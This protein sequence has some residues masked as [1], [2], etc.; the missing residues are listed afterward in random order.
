VSLKCSV[1]AYQLRECQQSDTELIPLLE[2][3]LC[4]SE[5]AKVPSCFYMKSG[6]L[7]RKW[8]PPT[9]AADEEWRVGHQT[10]VPNCYCDD[11][12]SLEHELPL[13]G[14]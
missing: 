4:E 11:I 2:D 12:L 3:V 5:A 14:I 10:V 9:V 6:I 1:P 13:Q 7:M 8:R